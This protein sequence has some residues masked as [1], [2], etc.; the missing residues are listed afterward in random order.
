MALYV[1]SNEVSTNKPTH[2]SLTMD[3]GA[4]FDTPSQVVG[5]NVRLHYDVT[6]IAAGTHNM[7]V[8]AVIIDAVQGRLESASVP[9]SF[10]KLASPTAPSGIALSVT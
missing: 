10:V 6:S 4:S 5:S 7:T 8:K 1:V 9:F 3:G 2:Y